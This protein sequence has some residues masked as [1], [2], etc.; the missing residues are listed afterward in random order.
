MR[1]KLRNRLF[2][3]LNNWSERLRIPCTFR[4]LGEI[5]DILA[6]AN[7]NGGMV[8]TAEE[9]FYLTER[10]RIHG[11][12]DKDQYKHDMMTITKNAIT[13]ARQRYLREASRHRNIKDI[14]DMTGFWP[15]ACKIF[16]KLNNKL[17]KQ[18]Q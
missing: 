2:R 9:R 13:P 16:T 5:I 15:Y 11:L 17:A 14:I 4:L 10:T 18:R 6:L 3:L 7:Q 1:L 8:L 12:I